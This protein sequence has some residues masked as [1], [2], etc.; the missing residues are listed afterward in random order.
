MP[1]RY[2]PVSGRFRDHKGRFVS[3]RRGLGSPYAREQYYRAQVY[4]QSKISPKKLYNKIK[5]VDHKKIGTRD[6]VI[7]IYG[8]GS[9]VLSYSESIRKAFSIYGKRTETSQFIVTAKKRGK[10]LTASSYSRFND[11]M[12]EDWPEVLQGV[13]NRLIQSEGCIISVVITFKKFV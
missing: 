9:N 11:E 12:V 3:R 6:F 2:D 4:P 13:F 7:E 8:V 10:I 1:I 5:Q